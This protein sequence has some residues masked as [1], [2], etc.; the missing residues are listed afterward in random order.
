[1]TWTVRLAVLLLVS[2]F[3]LA[4]SLGLDVVLGAFTAGLIGSV[5]TIALVPLFAAVF[6]AARGTPA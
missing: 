1:M 4:G 6:I 5:G 3:L 2:L